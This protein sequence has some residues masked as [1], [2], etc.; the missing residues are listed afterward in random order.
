MSH[1]RQPYL[2]R[3]K[4]GREERERDDE[5]KHTHGHTREK[6]KIG[7]PQ[8]PSSL[9]VYG[10]P[11]FFF[12]RCLE[13]RRYFGAAK[14]LGRVCKLSPAFY[15]TGTQP[16]PFV[17]RGT[18]RRPLVK[19]CCHRPAQ[20]KPAGSKSFNERVKSEV[21]APHYSSSSVGSLP[22]ACAGTSIGTAAF[23]RRAAVDTQ[24]QTRVC[25]SLSYPLLAVPGCPF[26]H[27]RKPVTSVRWTLLRT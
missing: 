3:R 4:R 19:A 5:R 27:I 17:A 20:T 8:P 15:V 6:K 13:M 9:M 7:R 23:Q 1:H 10:A 12:R 18:E 14:N 16:R 26:C 2:C 21:Q 25:S 22:G 11:R 24:A